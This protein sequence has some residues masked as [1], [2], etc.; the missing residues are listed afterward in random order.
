MSVYIWVEGDHEKYVAFVE[1]NAV[2]GGFNYIVARKSTDKALA[3]GTTD[4]RSW[5]EVKDLICGLMDTPPVEWK[6]ESKSDIDDDE[7]DED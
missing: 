4:C 1:R 3:S 7:N 6:W 2:S 5:G